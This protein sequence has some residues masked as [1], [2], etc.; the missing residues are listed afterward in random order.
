MSKLTLNKI[1]KKLA[2][3]CGGLASWSNIDVTIVRILFI[4]TT[5]VGIGSPVIIYILLALIL[6]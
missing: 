3:V 5:L 4:L 1:D 6:D 2:G